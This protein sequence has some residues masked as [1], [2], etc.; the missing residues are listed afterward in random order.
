MAPS[1]VPSTPQR[2]TSHQCRAT[3]RTPSH[4]LDMLMFGA[5]SPAMRL[6]D[7]ASSAS[8]GSAKMPRVAGMSGMPSHR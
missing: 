6:R 7:T 1:P 5:L 3:S 8:S 2:S 4:W